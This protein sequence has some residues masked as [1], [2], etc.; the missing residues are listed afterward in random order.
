MPEVCGIIKR[1]KVMNYVVLVMA[2]LSLGLTSCGNDDGPDKDIA[3]NEVP[4]VVRN[5]FQQRFPNAKDV[6]WELSGNDYG[7]DFEID[8]VDHKALIAPEGNLVKYKYDIADTALPETVMAKIA[9]DHGNRKID[10]SEVLKIGESTYYQVELDGEPN[11]Q[12]LVFVESGEVD[13]DVPYYD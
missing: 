4:A 2:T 6:D 9:I 1:N 8:A 3:A 7:A 5:S 10:G 11:D 12:N 13:T